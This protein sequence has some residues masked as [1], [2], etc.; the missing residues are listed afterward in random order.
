MKK[1]FMVIGLYRICVLQI[2]WGFF[3]I[4]FS[5]AAPEHVHHVNEAKSNLLYFKNINSE[6]LSFFS[7]KPQ[8]QT[9]LQVW[10]NSDPT[11]EELENLKT[12]QS[13]K[14]ITLVF[15]EP[16]APFLKDAYL[17]L[18]TV[19]KTQKQELL[20]KFLKTWPTAFEAEVLKPICNTETKITFLV[21]SLPTT[22]EAANIQSLKNCVHVYFS[23]GRYFHYKDLETVRLLKEIPLTLVNNY[24]PANSHADNLNLIG[25][26]IHLWIVHIFPLAE[27]IPYLNQIKQLESLHWELDFYPTKEQYEVLNLLR[28]EDLRDA[29]PTKYNVRR[30]MHWAYGTPRELDLEY[31]KKL[32]LDRI[33]LSLANFSKEEMKQKLLDLNSELIIVEDD[34]LS[35]TNE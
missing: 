4:Q 10:F 29:N 35:S 3:F 16:V 14:K 34:S 6:N 23:I 25:N 5:L 28:P 27:Q 17:D 1:Y 24:H 8:R 11:V 21:D 33:Q 30:S 26:P 15:K 31:W 13:L 18:A 12:Y 22:A 32:K 9:W 20:L 7:P 2:L 19:L